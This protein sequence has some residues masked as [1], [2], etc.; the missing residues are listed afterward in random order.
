MTAT[1]LDI[2]I[3]QGTDYDTPFTFDFDLTG[4]SAYMQIRLATGYPYAILSLTSLAGGLL[5]DTAAGTVLPVISEAVS[6]AIN[7]GRYVYDLKLVS[8]FGK[9]SRPYQGDA[10]VSAEV[11]DNDEIPV[12]LPDAL[13]LESG[14]YLLLENGGRLLLDEGTALPSSSILLEDG[15]YLL[16]E[17]GGHLLLEDGTVPSYGAILLESGGY[18][19]NETGGKFNLEA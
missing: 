14:G 7:A 5:I 10:Y 17:S 8:P 2:T 9:H 13:L 6:A 3:E 12:V 18:L 1:R 4:Y 11:T 16:L 15:S 19:L